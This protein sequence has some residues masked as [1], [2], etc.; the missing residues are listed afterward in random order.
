MNLWKY[1]NPK[2]S[3]DFR[4]I[5]N[6]GNSTP[7]GSHLFPQYW[8]YKYADPSDCDLLNHPIAIW[9]KEGVQ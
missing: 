8:G 1:P 7:S 6:E 3:N 5:N 9:I 2:G 4:T